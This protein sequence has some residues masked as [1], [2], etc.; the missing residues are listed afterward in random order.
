MNATR[1]WLAV[2]LL[3]LAG[4]CGGEPAFVRQMEKAALVESLRA[5][6]LESVEAEKSAVLATDDEEARGFAEESKHSSEEIGRL[7]SRLSALVAVDARGEEVEALASL[8]AALS[9]LEK[10]DAR[11][12]ALAVANSNLK[13]AQLAARDGAAALD[14]LLASLDAMARASPNVEAV[15]SLAAA[16]VAAARIQSLLLVH[17]PEASD[18]EMDAL[19]AR[20]RKLAA[21]VDASLHGVAPKLPRS[22][23]KAAADATRAWSEY[24]RIAAEVVRLSRLNTDVLSYDVSVHEKRT[25]TRACLD[26]LA[27]LRSAIESGPRATR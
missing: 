23:S 26:A 3:T 15:R 12:L 8:S 10:L 6:L 18:A 9:E 16:A 11:L 13:A 25:A 5:D 24:Q 4:G 21:T 27:A 20:M 1:W 7:E 14:E 19:E 22:A 2:C 17:V